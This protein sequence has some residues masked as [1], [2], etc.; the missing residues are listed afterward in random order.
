ML[1]FAGF[2][3]Y[4]A[5]QSS[6]IFQDQKIKN[7]VCFALVAMTTFIMSNIGGF[8]YRG[9]VI[10]IGAMFGTTMA[11][12]VWFRIWPAQQKIIAAIKAGTPPDAALVGL[13][14]LRSRHNTYMSAALIWTMIDIHTM[15]F[16]SGVPV[17]GTS[18]EITLLVMILLAW[19]VVFQLYKR[20]G[21]VKGF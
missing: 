17:P 12:N 19:H 9:Y 1:T 21:Q 15:G 6:G 14:G 16:F 5:I 8:G 7:A 13:A 4:D 10:H 3:V 2:A 18:Q 11:F 20:A